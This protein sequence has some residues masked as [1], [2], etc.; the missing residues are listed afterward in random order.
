MLDLTPDGDRVTAAIVGGSSVADRDKFYVGIYNGKDGSVVTRLPLNGRE[1]VAISPDGKLLAV[2]QQVALTDGRVEPTVGIFDIASGNQVGKV[3]HQAAIV[4]G[5][6]NSGKGAIGS[7]FTPDGKYLITSG[8]SD[9]M[10][11]TI[12]R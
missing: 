5:F 9:T 4:S 2:S 8:V 12:Q 3:S 10:V 1:G 6:G 11:W 7:R